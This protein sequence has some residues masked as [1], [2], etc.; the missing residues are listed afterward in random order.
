MS[1]SLRDLALCHYLRVNGVARYEL[2]IEKFYRDRDS[3]RKRIKLLAQ[4]GMIEVCLLAELH[5]IAPLLKQ[6]LLEFG[7]TKRLDGIKFLRLGSKLRDNATHS[8][9]KFSDYE[10][11]AH[12]FIV[13]EAENSLRKSFPNSKVTAES[14]LLFQS[15]LAKL[16]ENYYPDLIIESGMGQGSKLKIG[17][18]I[19]RTRKAK[20]RL[21]SKLR[22][23]RNSSYTHVVYF[24]GTPE[25]AHLVMNQGRMDSKLAVGLIPDFSTVFNRNGQPISIGNFAS[26][27][28]S[29]FSQAMTFQDAIDQL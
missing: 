22:H 29:K 15:V 10:Y 4:F 11:W 24:C 25:I 5:G 9:Q 1:L 28:L 26:E 7:F 27:R 2:A 20:K 21:E 12:Q 13:T 17:I 14:E 23:Y 3:G 18:E 8:F 19:E 16:P 6:L